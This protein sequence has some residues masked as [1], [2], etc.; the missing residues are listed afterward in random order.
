MLRKPKTVTECSLQPIN[1]SLISTVLREELAL[2]CCIKRA[3]LTLCRG[4]LLS[5]VQMHFCLRGLE[6]SKFVFHSH[7]PDS[8]SLVVLG[9][10]G[11]E[12]RGSV[13]KTDLTGIICDQFCKAYL[14]H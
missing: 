11:N 4:Y 2:F 14:D 5:E 13:V 10:G 12:K 6:P 3:R 9:H 7:S 1:H 8:P